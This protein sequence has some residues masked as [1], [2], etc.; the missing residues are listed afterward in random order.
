MSY[1]DGLASGLDTTSIINSLMQVEAIPKTLLENKATNIKAGL[2]SYASIR[3]KV[4]AVR[5]AAEALSSN[6]GWSPLTASSSNS[7]VVS[8]SAGT[9]T[10][11]GSLTFSVVSLATAMQRSS[12]DTFAGLDADLGGRTLSLTKG[13]H[14][15]D[16][17]ATTLSGLVDEINADADLGV[18][19][20]AL[21]VSP[22]S[23]RLVL[24]AKETGVDNS[25]TASGTGWT[26]AFDVTTVAKDAQLDVGG[27]TVTRPSNTISDLLPGATLNLKATSATPV[28][29]NVQR[30]AEAVSTKVEALVKALNGAIDEI[31]LR[32]AYNAETQQR[33]SLTGDSTART[34]AQRMTDA[35]I[36]EVEG[37]ALST[38][39]LAGVELGRDGRFTFD[40]AE[41]KAA[42]AD[43][44]S[45]VQRLFVEGGD[46]TGGVGFK[47]AGWRAQAGTY[48]VEV[49]ENA[50]VYTA[51]IDGETAEV[52]VND[53]GSLKIA[54]DTLHERLGGLT[55]TVDAGSLPVGGTS[56]VGTITYAPGTAKRL[57]S[58][59]NRTLDPLDGT[60]TSAEDSRKARIKDIERQ[61]E[62]W[63]LRLDKREAALRRQYTA[64]ESMMGQLAN[65]ST[66]L[67]GQL[68][69]LSANNAK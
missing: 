13:T 32:T 49:T 4:A 65:Q 46:T 48:T 60:L 34:V 10:P 40:A 3:T 61:V 28:T 43:D 8:A 39:G 53:D 17:S 36:A 18:R 27:I 30:D 35:V 1:I 6:T 54:M 44:P 63:E 37:A 21:Q 20:T 41:F 19:A 15:F 33:S 50:G 57:V 7:E 47:S 31:K 68:G 45:A 64:L 55:L 11:G 23:Y 59:A 9:G 52:T 69:S 56:E 2:D 58:M 29:V 14:T 42:Y 66:W 67:A 62:A 38:V 12:T 16:S 26:G 51:T 5:T 22:G 24:S 25:F